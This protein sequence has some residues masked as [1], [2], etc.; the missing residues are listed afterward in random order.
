MKRYFAFLVTTLVGIHS[1][2]GFSDAQEEQ[3]FVIVTQ[4][5]TG[6]VIDPADNPQL[7]TEELSEEQTAILN[8][9]S[10]VE[11]LGTE[12]EILVEL[13]GNT[14]SFSAIDPLVLDRIEAE[15][16]TWARPLPA[17][18]AAGNIAGYLALSN[19]RPDNAVYMFRPLNGN[20]ITIRIFGNGSMLS[21]Q[22]I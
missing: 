6:P 3:D 8:A 19:L 21:R 1:S 10:Q 9:L 22:K 17:P 20:A 13:L 16:L 15:I 12:I 14:T 18:N 11:N 2:V 7:Q 5:P 4:T